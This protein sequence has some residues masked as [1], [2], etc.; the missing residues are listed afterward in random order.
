MRSHVPAIKTCLHR[1][2]D[3]VAIACRSNLTNS[4]CSGCIQTDNH[5]L[6]K[7]P[8]YY[9][10]QL[11][12]TL[13][14]DRPLKIE[15][16][17]PT[18]TGARLERDPLVRGDAVILLAVNDGL[19]ADH[20]AARFFGIRAGRRCARSSRRGMDTGRHT[21]RRRARRD[22]QLCR[23]RASR[24]APIDDHTQ[25]GAV[26]LPVPAALADR[27]QMA[28]GKVGWAPPTGEG[29]GHS[30]GRCAKPALV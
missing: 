13:A 22:Q 10:Q 30:G 5:R 18:N 4:F 11:Y 7:T 26:R 1:H 21:E 24:A 2:C 15:S 12:A 29:P 19:E 25:F 8:V 9:A 28:N 3:L 23:A 14:G 20:A 6:Y 27:A 16:P 17:L